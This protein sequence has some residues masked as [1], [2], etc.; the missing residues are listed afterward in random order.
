VRRAFLVDD[1]LDAL[2]HQSRRSLLR[3]LRVV[4]EGE[5]AIDEGGVRK[6]FFQELM[7]QLFNVDYGMFEWLDEPRV[8]WFS[9]ASVDE[10]EFFLV[11]LV[12]GLAV[13]NGVI[14]DLHFPPV[15]W[16]RVFNEPVGFAHLPQ[17]QPDLCR[18]LSA[19]LA[20]DGDVE[21]AFCA[22]FSVTTNALGALQVTELVPNGS[23]KPVTNSNRHEYVERYA[24]WWLIDSI[25]SQFEAF[26]KGF[27]L[28]CDGVAFSFL[29]PSELEELVCGTPHLDFQAL[30]ANARYCDGFH[31]NDPTIK[32]F[33]EVVHSMN[34]SDK[35]ALLL[36]A[37]GCDRA[38]VGGLGKLQFVLQRAGPDAMDLPTSHTCFNML[39]MPAYQSRAKLRDRLTIA[40]HNATGFGLQ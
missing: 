13:Y 16:Q 24:A 34:I 23:E 30:E 8:F 4:F 21:S 9:R 20:Y 15:L 18:G 31:P 14:L 35:R 10:A 6:E 5:P 28:L 29:T 3:P 11:G 2:A 37:T 25:R 32:F 1:A 22:D 17:I 19:L 12:L 33:W 36:F 26:Q 39:S 40:I 38:P 7:H 27:L